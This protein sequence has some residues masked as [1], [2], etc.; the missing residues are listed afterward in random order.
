MVERIKADSLRAGLRERIPERD[1]ISRADEEI[2]TILRRVSRANEMKRLIV[3]SHSD[4]LPAFNLCRLFTECCVNDLRST[5]AL[6][7]DE[8]GLVR[9]ILDTEIARECEAFERF[10]DAL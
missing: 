7:R 8:H 1:G 9:Q 6:Q 5:R 4:D 10:Q 2:E 3:P